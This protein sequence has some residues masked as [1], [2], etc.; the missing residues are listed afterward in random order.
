M[1]S[2]HCRFP[3]CPDENTI[4]SLLEG[5][6]SEDQIAQVEFAIDRCPDCQ[7]LMVELAHML[8]LPQPSL[9]NTAPQ[10]TP[11][12]EPAQEQVFVHNIGRYRILNTLGK[13]GMSVVYEAY[14]EPLHRRVALKVTRPDIFSEHL[15][16]SLFARLLREGR[17]LAQLQH[18]N[19]P[20]VYEVG[21]WDNQIYMAI[22]LVRGQTLRAWT[23]QR[24]ADWREILRHYMEAGKAIE[25][26][27]Q[28]GII[29]RDIKPDNIL[30]DDMD[31]VFLVDF[32]LAR[33]T[34]SSKRSLLPFTPKPVISAI[35]HPKMPYAT[36]T[37]IMLGTPA[38]MSPEQFYGQD[39]DERSD[40]F[41]FCF[42]LYEALCGMSPYGGADLQEKMTSIH[43]GEIIL[44][45][46]SPVPQALFEVLVKGLRPLPDQR[47]SS[48]KDLLTALEETKAPPP[49]KRAPVTILAAFGLIVALLLAI[50]FL[51]PGDTEKAN[52]H[53]DASSTRTHT[54]LKMLLSPPPPRKRADT[55]QTT[56]PHR[57]RRKEP[58]RRRSDRV[59]RPI[60]RTPDR[61]PL[62][63]RKRP[64]TRRSSLPAGLRS[65]T[66]RVEQAHKQKSSAQCMKLHREY[67]SKER[68]F[69]H[70]K[71]R[72]N[73]QYKEALSATLRTLALCLY[74][75]STS[76]CSTIVSI[77][78]RSYEL[79]RE[80]VLKRAFSAHLQDAFD[81]LFPRCLRTLKKSLRRTPAPST[82]ILKRGTSERERKYLR[83]LDQALAQYDT[84]RCQKW[85]VY[86][87]RL[88]RPRDR[89]PIR[90]A[91]CQML[92]GRC[93][94]NVAIIK[95]ALRKR[96]IQP[97]AYH[98]ERYALRFC[99]VDRNTA[100]R[101][102]ALRRYVAN[103]K[104][105][106]YLHCN[107]VGLTYWAFWRRR[108]RALRYQ[109][110]VAVALSDGIQEVITCVQR[111]KRSC[112]RMRHFYR[113]LRFVH[114]GSSLP[115]TPSFY[116][117]Y[118]TCR[119]RAQKHSIIQ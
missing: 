5:T 80:R 98:V 13:G 50:V 116:E 2:L 79:Q 20:V 15:R 57:S 27:H 75:R 70:P 94:E 23:K 113:L 48:M 19:I 44:P 58:L 45:T 107:L 7:E 117:L 28:A 3:E 40:Q 89:H 97:D 111:T 104:M 29:H 56:P 11:K 112:R 10:E 115:R 35:D 54:P 88:G 93:E 102:N 105:R 100:S 18:P 52:T 8:D 85:L 99:A 77:W 59:V 1:S 103:P 34:P 64:P 71:M 26:A 114:N 68:T 49:P 119:S 86:L 12:K 73:F 61:K 84:R 69:L 53:P 37:G 110:D 17:L 81:H 63:L 91:Q 60:K 21:E 55:T 74:N 41:S 78:K 108:K 39:A 66:T 9:T 72:T 42:A 67:R 30:I 109:K 31:R 32:G 101:I 6:L 38:Y 76:R 106:R 96:H 51:K 92:N 87:E 90:Y 65:L 22:Q 43:Q 82:N 62:Q 46:E 16:E 33:A 24:D 4:V 14:D 36:K 47:F 118:P 95:G 25:A 83:R